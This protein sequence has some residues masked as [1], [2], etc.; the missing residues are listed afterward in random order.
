LRL[1][2]RAIEEMRSDGKSDSTGFFILS[3][4]LDTRARGLV[5]GAAARR[6]RGER[7]AAESAGEALRILET[8][9]PLDSLTLALER[10]R[11]A[12]LEAARGDAET[13]TRELVSARRTLGMILGVASFE[14]EDDSSSSSSSS[15][16]DEVF[17]A[18]EFGCAF[19]RRALRIVEALFASLPETTPGGAAEGALYELD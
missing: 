1:V 6:A 2:E 9:Y 17:D 3:V 8:M 5:G 13:A 11:Y 7:D 14:D 15:S 16:D 4:A 18:R 19:E 12:A 10:A